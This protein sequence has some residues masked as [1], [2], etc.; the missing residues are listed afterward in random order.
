M[1]TATWV[2]DLDAPAAVRDEL[3]RLLATQ[4][5]KVPWVGLRRRVREEVDLV[6]RRAWQQLLREAFIAMTA[7]DDRHILP[8]AAPPTA[9]MRQR[10]ASLPTPAQKTGAASSCAPRNSPSVG[11]RWCTK[12]S[13]SYLSYLSAYDDPL[14]LGD[15]L[16]DALARHTQVLADLRES[17][18]GCPAL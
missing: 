17:R 13:P 2:A 14:G 11:S 8:A 9:P 6:V 5:L 12:P 18:A 3:Q 15:D 7:E 1:T 16:A 4:G 10:R